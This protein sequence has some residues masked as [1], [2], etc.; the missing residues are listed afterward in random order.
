MRNRSVTLCAVDVVGAIADPVRRDILALLRHGPR[1]AG[2]VA[3]AFAISRPAV[4]RHLR[5]L[6]ETGLVVDQ[7]RGRERHYRLDVAP[8]AEVDAW[9]AQFRHGWGASL[10]ALETEVYRTRR[11]R[12]ERREQREPA[13][14]PGPTGSTGPTGA[15]D[16]TPGRARTADRSEQARATV[17]N[18]ERTA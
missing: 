12:R 14:R 6:R 9:L 5:V 11:E 17:P 15:V 2:G 4:S 8:L 16:R 7:A 10:D 3:A 1:T 18:E 13:D